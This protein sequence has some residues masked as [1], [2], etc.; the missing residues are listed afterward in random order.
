M[1]PLRLMVYRHSVFYTPV[2]GG[3][4][5]GFFAAEGFRPAYTVMPAGESVAGMIGSGA[6]DVSQAAVSASWPF[7]ERGEQPPFMSFAQINCRDGFLLASR[8]PQADFRWEML[9]EGRMTF[10]HG[11]QPEAMLAYA[12]HRKGV[13]FEII[14]RNGIDAG[15]PE[16]AMQ[17]FR[18]GQG[19]WFH[20]QGPWAQQLVF[21]HAAHV[22][23]AVDEAIGP[24][25]FS[26]LVAA[27]AW[28]AR[29][30]APRFMRAHAKARHWA[31]TAPPARVA[32]VLQPYFPAVA[33]GALESAIDF[34]QSLGCWGG[35]C[36]I[37]RAHYDTALD[38]FAHSKL[39]TRRH[40]YE[41]VV[42][43]PPQ[44]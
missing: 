29:P 30:E 18:A 33:A 41:R 20:E 16:S 19:D 1:V 2:I 43:A 44:A 42:T 37:E 6:I 25:A 31:H 27:P 3:I 39:I 21:E 7:L 34:Y 35:S 28:L 38:V 10:A 9:R 36:A 32:A 26:S 4:A 12:L 17:A 11:G 22:V 5:A 8:R 14:R 15:G 23:A 24:V 40:P 13:D